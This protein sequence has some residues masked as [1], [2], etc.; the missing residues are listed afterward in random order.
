MA[1]HSGNTTRRETSPK[2]IGSVVSSKKS[3]VSC[4]IFDWV[5]AA[6][7]DPP[8]T[9]GNTASSSPARTSDLRR[10]S[11]LIARATNARSGA[12]LEMRR[13][14]GRRHWLR[15]WGHPGREWCQLFRLRPARRQKNG[16]V[17]LSVPRALRTC[18]LDLYLFA[19]V[20]IAFGNLVNASSFLITSDCTRQHV[21]HRRRSFRSKR[22]PATPLSL[23]HLIAVL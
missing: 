2:S 10:D 1:P 22:S 19:A 17:R 14:L 11:S 15:P 7:S 18:L 6:F 4:G 12:N 16:R 3:C 21:A 23:F 9:G 20:T 13:Q 5:D 8:L